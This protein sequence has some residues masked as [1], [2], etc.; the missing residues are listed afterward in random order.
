MAD[1]IHRA[2]VRTVTA[3]RNDDLLEGEGTLLSRLIHP[4]TPSEFMFVYQRQAL[5]VVPPDTVDPGFEQRCARVRDELVFGLDLRDMLENTLSES[6]HV[7]LRNASSTG[8]GSVAS[9]EVQDVETAGKLYSSGA[10]LY[11]RGSQQC[12][13]VLVRTLA[14]D[15][16]LSFGGFYS[17]GAVMLAMQQ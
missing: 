9:F 3:T 15:L 11:F 17:N 13:D 7:W 14:K 4:M 6:I 5:A 8:P 12:T 2:A 16:G 10:S 1:R